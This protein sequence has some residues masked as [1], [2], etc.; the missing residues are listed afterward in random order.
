M[1]LLTI[2]SLPKFL[3]LVKATYL[4]NLGILN[5][6]QSYVNLKSDLWDDPWLMSML[7]SAKATLDRALQVL[8]RGPRGS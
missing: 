8:H 7:R 2:V 5:S 3:S 4:Y 6:H 1:M